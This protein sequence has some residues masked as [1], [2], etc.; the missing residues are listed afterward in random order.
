MIPRPGG[1]GGRGHKSRGRSRRCSCHEGPTA[2]GRKYLGERPFPSVRNALVAT[3][4][5]EGRFPLNAPAASSRGAPISLSVENASRESARSRNAGSAALR[6]Q[7]CGSRPGKGIL[8]RVPSA[9]PRTIE[10]RPTSTPSPSASARSSRRPS[11]RGSRTTPSRRTGR[12]DPRPAAGRAYTATGPRTFTTPLTTSCD[13][14]STLVGCS[15]I[16]LKRPTGCSRRLSRPSW[17]SKLPAPT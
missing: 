12:C 1:R 8:G 11:R 17:R 14:S 4:R 9:A 16:E 2:P 3:F 7:R 5:P 15:P 13:R 10:S 6:L